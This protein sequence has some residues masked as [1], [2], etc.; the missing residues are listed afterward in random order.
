MRDVDLL[1]ATMKAMVLDVPGHPLVLKE[2][3]VPVPS[4]GQ[5]VVKVMACGVCRTDLHIMDSEL[6]HPKLPL[7]PGHEIVGTVVR[8]GSAVTTLKT[9][10]VVGI[11]WVGYTCGHCRYCLRFWIPHRVFMLLATPLQFI[12]D[13][14][15]S[16]GKK[17]DK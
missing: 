8:T 4:T 12:R 5:V 1:P 11:P 17:S 13:A 15:K 2:V 6:T 14:E 10:D 7:I 3:P 16:W 9:G